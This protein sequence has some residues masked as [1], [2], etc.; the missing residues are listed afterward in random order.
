MMTRLALRL[1][2]R[3]WN[4]IH[5]VT[6]FARLEEVEEGADPQMYYVLACGPRFRSRQHALPLNSGQLSGPCCRVCWSRLVSEE[7]VA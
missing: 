1:P 3:D 7:A 2:G 5:R 6:T 4:L